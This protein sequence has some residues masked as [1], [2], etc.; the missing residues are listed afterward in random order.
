MVEAKGIFSI[1]IIQTL[2]SGLIFFTGK[3]I[4]REK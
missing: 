3:E 2:I 4:G 1:P